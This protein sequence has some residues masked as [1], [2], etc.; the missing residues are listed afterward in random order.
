MSE[1]KK[2]VINKHSPGWLGLLGVIFVVAK[3]FEIGPVAAWSWWVVLL[4]F[5]FWIAFFFA[6]GFGTMALGGIM[7]AGAWCIDEYN[8]RKRRK[9]AEKARVWDV[10]K[11]K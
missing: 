1:E 4:P 10:L 6:I 2:V 8:R 11:R 5:Y 7:F 9:Q 3:V